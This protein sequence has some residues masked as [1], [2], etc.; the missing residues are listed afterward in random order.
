MNHWKHEK[1]RK[2]REEKKARKKARKVKFNPDTESIAKNKE[3]L[4]EHRKNAAEAYVDLQERTSLIEIKDTSS[5]DKKLVEKLDEIGIP[6]ENR[7]YLKVKY[8]GT[9]PVDE[10]EK[11]GGFNL[12]EGRDKVSHVT[13]SNKTI[14][15]VDKTKSRAFF[16]KKYV[17][18]ENHKVSLVYLDGL[19][20]YSVVHLCNAMSDKAFLDK[21]KLREDLD[22]NNNI[23][24]T[25]CGFSG[26][27]NKQA[28][29]QGMLKNEDAR[30]SLFGN[31]SHNKVEILEA[32]IKC[33]S[34]GKSARMEYVNADGKTK[35]IMAGNQIKRRVYGCNKLPE[36]NAFLQE[37]H[38][39]LKTFAPF[40]HVPKVDNSKKSRKHFQKQPLPEMSLAYNIMDAA[41][42]FGRCWHR[43]KECQFPTIVSAD[44]GEVE[45]QSESLNNADSG[46]LVHEIG[47]VIH[48]YGRKDYLIFSGA[49]LHCPMPTVPAH[50]PKKKS[51][52]K[53]VRERARAI[54]RS[55]VL[56]YK[57]RTK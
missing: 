30:R 27:P 33:Q 50:T 48:G 13:V 10:M 39:I 36:D 17:K 54:R 55:F 26:Y 53:G 14:K 16:R 20:D 5:I 8:N 43:D 1:K 23:W 45:L 2:E 57:P 24:T 46:M 6:K 32:S 47:G 22:S 12:L 3:G 40:I 7:V 56:F 35:S 28:M 51:S 44:G 31:T 52:K 15:I 19:D 41:C 37:S 9:D 21:M 4:K 18:G 38:E 42:P 29:E 25:G 11:R 49:N 34:T